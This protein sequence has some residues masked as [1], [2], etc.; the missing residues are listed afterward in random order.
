MLLQSRVQAWK[1]QAIGKPPAWPWLLHPPH[2]SHAQGVCVPVPPALAPPAALAW[3]PWP[4]PSH[5]QSGEP[6]TLGLLGL[7]APCPVWGC[8]LS[9]MGFAGD[10][11][12]DLS[13]QLGLRWPDRA[14]RVNEHLLLVWCLGSQGAAMSPGAAGALLARARSCADGV[15]QVSAGGSSIFLRPGIPEDSGTE[16]SLLVPAWPVC[17]SRELEAF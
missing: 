4:P 11:V 1:R 7:H 12:L 9:G 17:P 10:D 5:R 13:G 2:W 3:Q 6:A 14:N 16:G 8:T 15:A